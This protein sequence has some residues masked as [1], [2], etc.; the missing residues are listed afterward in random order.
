MIK[1]DF[2]GISIDTEKDFIDAEKYLSRMLKFF[3]KLILT[4]ILGWKLNGLLPKDKK[5]IIAVVLIQ[6]HLI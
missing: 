5:Y 1:I 2:H 3:S 4:N 6:N